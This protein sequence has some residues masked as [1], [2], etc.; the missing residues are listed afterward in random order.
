MTKITKIDKF[1][2]PSKKR[3]LKGYKPVKVLKFP[4]EVYIAVVAILLAVLA[5]I[6]FKETVVDSFTQKAEAHYEDPCLELSRYVNG[7]D[8]EVI[9]YCYGG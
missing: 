2:W 7:S 3:E 9:E 4:V 6:Y 8:P 5:G 1:D